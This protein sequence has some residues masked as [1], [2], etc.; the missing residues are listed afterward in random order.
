MPL[1]VVEGSS[2]SKSCRAAAT[3]K[4][5]DDATSLH[6]ESDEVNLS[7]V[8][9]VHNHSVLRGR[10]KVNTEISPAIQSNTIVQSDISIVARRRGGESG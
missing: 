1:S 5:V 4:H 3:V 8:G 6:I 7:L 9:H 10:L 2:A